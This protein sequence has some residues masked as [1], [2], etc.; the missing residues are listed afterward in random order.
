MVWP[1]SAITRLTRSVP[2][3]PPEW[4]RG[5]WVKTTMSPSRS[6]CQLKNAFCKQDPAID[7]KRRNHG[8]A[9]DREDLEHER[10][11]AQRQQQHQCHG[12]CPS[13][14]GAAPRWRRLARVKRAARRAPGS[15]ARS[16]GAPPRSAVVMPVTA[17][18][19]AA[20]AAIPRIGGPPPPYRGWAGADGRRADGPAGRG[21]AG[22]GWAGR[23]WATLAALAGA[24]EDSRASGTPRSRPPAAARPPPHRRAVVTRSP[25]ACGPRL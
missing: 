10:P 2:A 3:G 9:G 15:P 16:S 21:W 12:D 4:S 19:C 7:V 24:D 6:W 20:P 25:A 8:G 22:R 11:D 14:E 18:R 13:G 5:G 1:G 17:V 23:E